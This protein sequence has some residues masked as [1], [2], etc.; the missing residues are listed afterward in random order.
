VN[1]AFATAPEEVQRRAISLTEVLEERL[2][3]TEVLLMLLA[4]LNH[5]LRS[6]AADA[7]A[8]GKRFDDYCPQIG[9]ELSIESAGRRTT[10]QC[11]GIA[12][13]GALLLDTFS[14]RQR[15]YS[16]VLR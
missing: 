9:H 3:R 8:F 13:D 5:S 10:G 11:A 4:K 12:V 7:D 6:L 1:N 16:G 14:G 2:D 15:F